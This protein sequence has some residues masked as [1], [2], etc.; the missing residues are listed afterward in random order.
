[1]S[2]RPRGFIAD[3][4]PRAQVQGV[5]DE[6]AHQLSLTLRQ[7]FYRLG[8]RALDELLAEFGRKHL[9]RSAI[10]TK[11]RRYI[12]RLTP[13]LLRAARCELSIT[14]PGRWGP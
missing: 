12:E 8:P 9:I 5:L 6:H 4:H 10:E 7:I 14:P 11:L 13:S 2:A 1:M 3:W